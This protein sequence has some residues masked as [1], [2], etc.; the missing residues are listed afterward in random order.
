MGMTAASA[1]WFLPVMTPIALYIAYND[2]RTMKIT[3]ATIVAL[4]VAYA[5]VG[6]FAFGLE[7]YLWQ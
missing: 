5:V 6:P 4:V 7:L 2:M 3:N 1:L